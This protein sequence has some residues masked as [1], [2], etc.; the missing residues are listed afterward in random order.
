MDL[1]FLPRIILLDNAWYY[2][3]LNRKGRY[4]TQGWSSVPT[5]LRKRRISCNIEGASSSLWALPL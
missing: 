5:V 1:C 3:C 2:A 4:N